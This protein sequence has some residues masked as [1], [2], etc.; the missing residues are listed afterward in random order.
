MALGTHIRAQ[1]IAWKSDGFTVQGW[2]LSLLN[3]TPGKHPMLVSI[4]GGPSAA[5]GPSYF[6]GKTAQQYIDRGYFLFYP[7]PRGS[8]G[9][10]EAFTRANYRDFGGGDL[11][12]ILSGHRRSGE[13]R[14]VDDTEAGHHRRLPPAASW[15]CM[16]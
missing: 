10:G 11:R 9:Q 16:P 1:S 6:G 3:P 8:Y 4:H 15:P 2:L 7:N 5:T 12:D 13:D 14:P